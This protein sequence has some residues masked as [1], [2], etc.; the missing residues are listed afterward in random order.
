MSSDNT[1]LRKK[2]TISNVIVV[3]IQF[4]EDSSCDFYEYITCTW[5][6][7]YS[8]IIK[9]V[10]IIQQVAHL[11]HL[12]NYTVHTVVRQVQCMFIDDDC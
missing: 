8:F 11:V 4:V 3:P 9:I 5:I 1:N 12:E 2:F 7:Q 10:F 6:K